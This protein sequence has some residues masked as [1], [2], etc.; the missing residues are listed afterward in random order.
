MNLLAI[1]NNFIELTAA[2]DKE[3]AFKNILTV[4]STTTGHFLDTLFPKN[5]NVLRIIYKHRKDNSKI[6]NTTTN[7]D[8]ET[9]LSSTKKKFDLICLDPFHEYYESSNDFALLT[10]YLTDDGILISH[11]CYPQDKILTTKEFVKGVWCGV[12]YAAFIELAYK[13]PQWFYAVLNTDFGLGIVSK[14]KIQFVEQNLDRASQKTFIEMLQNDDENTYDYFA[15]HCKE[16]INMIDVP[17][18]SP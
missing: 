15:K 7:K 12:T 11:D 17:K 14:K 16:L 4:R 8:V 10:S 18:Q 13:N 6:E 1:P 2:L 9:I 5:T 3:F